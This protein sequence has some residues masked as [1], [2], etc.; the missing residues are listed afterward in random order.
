MRHLIV[1]A[2]L[3]VS[4]AFAQES[5]DRA[6]PAP[7][8]VLGYELGDRF[9]SHAAIERYLKA[10][11]QSAGARVRIIPYGETC[12]GRK[13]YLAVVSAPENIANLDEIRSKIASLTDPAATTEESAASI[14]RSVPAVAWLAYGVHGNEASGPEAALKVLYRLA[15]GT[16]EGT[17]ALL[18]NL[19]VI[20]DP[21]QNPDGHERYVNYQT[22][23]A[24]SRP[25]EDRNAMEHGDDWPGSRTNHY[26]F[27][28]NRDWAWQTQ[29]E[30]R[31]RVAAYRRWNPQVFADYHEMGYN[32]SYFFFPGAKPFNRNLPKSTI[33][34]ERIYG[35]ANAAAFD[36][37]GWSYW[38]GEEFDL[39]YP[40]FGDS[41]PSLNGAIGMTYEQAGSVGLRAKRTDETVLTLKDRMEHHFTTSMATLKATSDNREKRLLDFYRFFKEPLEDAKA[42]P[43]KAY[44]VDPSKDPSR[45]GRM[46]DLLLNQGVRVFRS[47]GEFS[48]DGLHT[49]MT[50][51]ALTKRFPSGSYVIPLDQPEKRLIATLMDPEPVYSDTFFYDISTWSL[52][53]AYG[54]ETYW[55][56]APVSAPMTRIDS[57]GPAPASVSGAG[58]TYAYLLPWETDD[59]AKALAWLLQNDYKAHVAMKEFS[60]GGRRYGRGT[61][62]IPVG[63]NKADIHDRVRQLSERYHVSFTGAQTGFT[64]SGINLGSDRAVRLR[65]P[66][67]IVAAGAPVSPESFGAI[68]SLFDQEYGINFVTVRLSQIPFIDLHD[69]TAIIFPDDYGGGG[70]YRSQL[71]SNAV[72]KLRTWIAAGGTFIGIDGGAVFASAG[73]IASVKLKEKKKEE[74]PEAKKDTLAKKEPKLSEE[75]LEKRMTVEQKARKNRLDA[76]P[77]TLMRVR[78]DASHP[79]GFGC[80]STVAVLKNSGTMFELSAS[81]YNVGMY[82]KSP[83]IS[84]YISPENEKR[85]EETPFLIHEQLG[86]GNIIL[87]ADDPNFRLFFQG[88][89][90]L[91]LNSVLLMPSIRDVRMTSE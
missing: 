15:S 89:N 79:L 61:I 76:I 13:L 31:A 36:A 29:G 68:W 64:E 21:L 47:S 3:A 42:G 85:L 67:I 82:P 16:D 83:R 18:R 73:K 60:I 70:G 9:S 7:A 71:D 37:K 51:A 59:A 44:I 1:C 26:Y 62:I 78:I 56:P 58:S 39:F 55:S 84:G 6:V 65:K 32:S 20:L 69:Y 80:D 52:P 12:E 38:S 90:K 41:W 91:F 17:A 40:G 2:A 10:V 57:V 8:S 19:V 4:A 43:V 74:A 25:V 87:F 33:D 75:E 53:L 46:I 88:L 72:Q 24:G 77:G 35:M 30:T 5:F 11:E 34:W 45:A 28:L 81:G 14:A 63:A 54:V 22:V 48:L 49:Y 23:R 50:K 86:S 27:D 66:N